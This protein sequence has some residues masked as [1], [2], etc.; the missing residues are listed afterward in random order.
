[1]LPLVSILIPAFNAERWIYHTIAS[2]VGQ[3]WP[4]KEIIVVDDGST[5]GT[6]NIARQFESDTF[7][8]VSQKNAGAAAA[9]NRAL[10]LSQ[11]AYIQWL[12]ADDLLAANK[13]EKQMDFARTIGNPKILLSGPW[14]HF[15]YRPSKARFRPSCLWCDLSPLD[16]LLRK[17]ETNDFMQ[18]A[19][20]LVSRELTD[21]AG[22]WDTRLLG[23]DDGE[24]FCRVI[25]ASAG[26]R[27]VPDAKV[28]YRRNTNSLRHIGRNSQ[29]L[30]AQFL[31]MG[32]TISYIRS[33]DDGPRARAACVKHLQTYLPYFYPERVDIVESSRVLAAVLGGS[34]E[35]PQLGWKYSWIQK[36]FGWVA[37]KQ[38]QIYY[39]HLKSSILAGWDHTMLRLGM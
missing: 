11:G 20:W 30:E 13:I 21:A 36:L 22:P 15:R 2:A 14:A 3:S 16:W 18:T 26:V 37:A 19:T 6:L 17:L 7:K 10:S 24:Y 27:F 23:D 25:K 8:V 38:A 32:L 35:T 34:L 1:M 31:S 29:K 4:R 5:D 33:I 28:F 9:R 39:N 12:D